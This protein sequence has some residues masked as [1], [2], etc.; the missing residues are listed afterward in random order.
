MIIKTSPFGRSDIDYFA[1]YD[2]EYAGPE[3]T[4][5]SIIKKSLLGMTAFY[6]TVFPLTYVSLFSTKHPLRGDDAGYCCA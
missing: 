5:K 2:P 4:H 1:E 6:Q 3:M